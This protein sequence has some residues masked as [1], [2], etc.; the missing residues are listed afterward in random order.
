MK[1]LISLFAVGMMMTGCLVVRETDK[2]FA[3]TAKTFLV[4]GD[5]ADASM[6]IPE[7]ATVVTITHIDG[8]LA[9]GLLS[10]TFISGTK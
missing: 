3:I 4:G 7:G 8:P 2:T 1:K 10:M 5:F 6:K 9:L